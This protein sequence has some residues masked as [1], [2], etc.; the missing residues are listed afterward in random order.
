[1]VEVQV[2]LATSP[3]TVESFETPL[4]IVPHNVYSSTRIQSYSSLDGLTDAGKKFLSDNEGKAESALLH[5]I[6][7]VCSIDENIKLSKKQ[8][9]G[10]VGALNNSLSE[11]TGQFERDTDLVQYILDN[12]ADI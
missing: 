4:F 7:S 2:N 5:L 9:D 8:F 6:V 12:K 1:V 11:I 3:T 10:I